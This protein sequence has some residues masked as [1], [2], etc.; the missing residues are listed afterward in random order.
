[1]I[2]YWFHFVCPAHHSE[3]LPSDLEGAAYTVEDLIGQKLYGRS[4]LTIV[5][6]VRVEFLFSSYQY[7]L[8]IIVCRLGEL[9]DNDNKEQELYV[10]CLI[11]EALL[12]L[13]GDGI[14]VS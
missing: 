11:S 5:K 6:S 13:F 9:P 4:P 14:S 2:Q 12:Q 10:E 7:V 3:L 8:H 1:M